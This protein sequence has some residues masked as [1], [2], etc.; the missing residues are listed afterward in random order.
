MGGAG[1]DLNVKGG[2]CALDAS[3]NLVPYIDLLMTIMTFFVMT[4]VWIQIAS[5]EI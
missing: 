4:A 5:L 3:V 2:K 1:P